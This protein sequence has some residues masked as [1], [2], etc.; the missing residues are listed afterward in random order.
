MNAAEY[1]QKT[2][3]N[4][5]ALDL[6]PALVEDLAEALREFV[7]DAGAAMP[8]HPDEA[9]LYTYRV[10]QLSEDGA[11]S[12][13]EELAAEPY[14]LATALGGRSRAATRKL[15]LLNQLIGEVHERLGA[16]W[17]GAYQRLELPSGPALVKLAYRGLESRAEFPLTE[18]FA[19][20]SN[21]SRVALSGRGAVIADVHA[22]AQAGGSYYVC[23]P[24]V[25]SEVCLPVYGEMSEVIG[26]I[27][28][29]DD[30][31]GFFDGTRQALAAALCLVLP[32]LY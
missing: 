8:A 16:D 28:A 12:L 17:L 26:I 1:L 30:A 18:S 25:S 4:K 5:N 7:A 19:E 32:D 3:L 10:P 20:K 13:V 14:D 22:H 24:K 23:D 27:D 6:D 2:G 29:E 21:N 11:C 15:W 9:A 31:Q